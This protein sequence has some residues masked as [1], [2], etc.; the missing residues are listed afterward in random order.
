MTY[1]SGLRLVNGLIQNIVQY[2]I[3]IEPWD[4]LLIWCRFL[5]K[6]IYSNGKFQIFLNKIHK[7]SL[8][9][10]IVLPLN[11]VLSQVCWFFL[12][13]ELLLGKFQMRS[14]NH[15]HSC[16]S[17]ETMIIF[18]TRLMFSI[19]FSRRWKSPGNRLSASTTVCSILRSFGR[20]SLCYMDSPLLSPHKAVFWSLM[21]RRRLF[22]ELEP[23]NFQTFFLPAVNIAFRFPTVSVNKDLARSLILIKAFYSFQNEEP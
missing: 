5:L 19:S 7:W 1:K 8:F 20:I 15:R 14:I 4:T 21:Q 3:P 12:P 18:K 23:R 13:H 6:H 11:P 10:N 2:F 17:T 9:H 16:G 22:L